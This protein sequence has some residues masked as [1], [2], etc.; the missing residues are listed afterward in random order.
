M[1]RSSLITM[2]WIILA[3]VGSTICLISDNPFSAG[4]AFISVLSIFALA[5]LVKRF[6]EQSLLFFI[7]LCFTL[8]APWGRAF[9]SVTPVTEQMGEFLFSS[10]SKAFHIPGISFSAFEIASAA[11]LFSCIFSDKEAT[12]RLFQSPTGKMAFWTALLLPIMCIFGSIQGVARGNSLG[13]ALTQT[14][15]IFSLP[16]WTL[17]GWYFANSETRMLRICKVFCFA[18]ALKCLQ[19]AL[20]FLTEPSLDFPGREFLVEHITSEFILTALSIMFSVFWFTNPTKFF[21]LSLF[22]ASG[23][24]MWVFLLNDRR[25]SLVGIGMTAAFGILTFPPRTVV[26]YWKL[27]AGV[28]STSLLYIGATWNVS[29]PLGFAAQTIQSLF[30]SPNESSKAYRDIENANLLSAAA[31]NV[32]LGLGFGRR[33]PIVFEMPDISGVYEGYDLIPHNTLLYV[34][35]FAGPLGIALLGAYVAINIAMTSQTWHNADTYFKRA[36]G[37]VVFSL[38]IRWMVFV[39]ADIGLIEI[40]ELMMIGIFLGGLW[41]MWDNKPT[42]PPIM[43]RSENE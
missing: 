12:K 5:P 36:M 42:D 22:A 20:L 43:R 18:V 33:F 13:I 10:L 34:W 17:I 2:G 23:I 41:S 9:Y 40:R 32:L 21:R 4:M 27:A 1:N 26:R 15:S 16:I 28:A 14:R 29:G 30:F 24:M 31:D 11:I 8:D 3:V 37:F 35:T 19:S 7:F 39:Y 6:P 25:A 38:V